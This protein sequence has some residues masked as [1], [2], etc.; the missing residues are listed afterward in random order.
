MQ[1]NKEKQTVYI[2]H[3]YN[4]LSPRFQIGENIKATR[5]LVSFTLLL[6]TALLAILGLR[7]LQFHYV[8]GDS[9]WATAFFWQVGAGARPEILM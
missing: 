4:S 7:F 9:D 3:Y 1:V 2:K 6:F 8:D 5:L